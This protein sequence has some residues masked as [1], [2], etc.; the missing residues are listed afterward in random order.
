MS[1]G[2]KDLTHH[3]VK[4]AAGN[5]TMYMCEAKTYIYIYMIDDEEGE[6]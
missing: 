2:E 1:A 3:D 4:K 6:H 5:K